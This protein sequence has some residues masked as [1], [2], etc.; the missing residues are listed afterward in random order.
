M[1]KDT[2]RS[3]LRNLWI[4]L[5]GRERRREPFPRRFHSLPRLETLENR[6]TPT[7]PSVSSIVRSSPLG[8]NT[9]A[10]SVSYT[11][12]FNQAVSG[13]DP[14]DFKVAATGGARAAT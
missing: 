6:L 1:R 12:T 14:T 2:W 5:T 13:V 4:A 9:N 8:P 3:W 7:A 10:V 11:V